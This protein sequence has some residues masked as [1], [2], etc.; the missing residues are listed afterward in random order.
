M[1]DP[2]EL[3][4]SDTFGMS[5][6]GRLSITNHPRSSRMSAACDRP[7]P[8]NPVITMNSFT[9][10]A[11]RPRS[12][13]VVTA[14]GTHGG[15][16]EH[17]DRGGGGG[18]AGSVGVVDPAGRRPQHLGAGELGQV[19]GVDAV[20]VVVDARRG[21][22]R[23]QRLAAGEALRE[24]VVVHESVEVHDVAAAVESVAEQSGV[25][26]AVPTRWAV[27]ADPR[28]RAVD[29]VLPGEVEAG[30][31]GA[32]AGRA[33][34]H[35]EGD[36]HQQHQHDRAD[37]ARALEH[38]GHAQP[39]RRPG[40][41]GQA[42]ALR[43][44]VPG[45]G[46]HRQ[47]DE[48][49]H[50]LGHQHHRHRG[51]RPRHPS[52]GVGLPVGRRQR[53]AQRLA[54][55]PAPH[56]HADPEHG[57]RR[58]HQARE[59][60]REAT[61]GQQAGVGRSGQLA[62]VGVARPPHVVRVPAGEPAPVPTRGQGP[63]LV[64]LDRRAGREQV[65]VADPEPGEPRS[66]HCGADRPPTQPPPPPGAHHH[67][68]R[69]EP[70][71]H[72]Q[73]EPG[74]HRHAGQHADDDG[75]AQA[76]ACGPTTPWPSPGRPAPAARACLPCRR[77]SSAWPPVRG[78]RRCRRSSAGPG[79]SHRQT[80]RTISSVAASRQARHSSRA[81]RRKAVWPGTSRPTPASRNCQRGW[82]PLVAWTPSKVKPW[83]ASMRRAISR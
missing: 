54:A 44:A 37:A 19:V 61:V 10:Q 50:G 13:A 34:V 18:A 77:R 63:Q 38:P 71:H 40:G 58:D 48:V 32:V 60:P 42:E 74:Q 59:P 51:Q 78:P 39:G 15:H 21:D 47:V 43:D 41:E 76:R 45:L 33:H 8:D 23:A 14:W 30:I 75:T 1:L 57:Q 7:A 55:P 70:Q 25:A 29:R 65:V 31:G 72:H 67:R 9:S 36:Q 73:V 53:Q 68:H 83:P 64:L 35:R 81:T 4:S 6:G 11:Y 17:V 27:L 2:G 5:S 28:R 12:P 49:E 24:R 66:G 26:R 62:D 16:V 3:A 46:P 82:N 80:S 56:E 20:H 52:R 22:E 79:P 69:H